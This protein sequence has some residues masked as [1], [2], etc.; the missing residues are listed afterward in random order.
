[1]I[2]FLYICLILI[3][4]SLLNYFLL[5]LSIPFLRKHF[6]RAPIERDSH[7]IP[8]PR[9]GGFVFVISSFLMVFVD[10]LKQMDWSV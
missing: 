7:K 3:L 10:Q 1:M 6:M 2:N 4:S 5:F 8:I 9:A